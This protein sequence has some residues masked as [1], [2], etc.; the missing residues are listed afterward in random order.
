MIIQIFQVLLLASAAGLC[1]ALVFYI[2]RITISFEKMQT[3]ISRLADE[4]HPLLESFEALSHSITKVTSYA[5]E[6][7]NSISWIVE[8][9]KSLVVSLLSVEKRIREGIEGPV[10]NLTTN[11]NAVKKGIATFVQR[12]KC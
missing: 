7:M 6:Q 4:I 3:D 11:L 12:L 5:E 2:K 9:V 8:S 10:Q 1:I